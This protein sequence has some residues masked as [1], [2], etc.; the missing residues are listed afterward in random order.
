LGSVDGG[1][2]RG[3]RDLGEGNVECEGGAFARARLYR[4]ESAELN[5]FLLR[6]TKSDPTAADGRDEVARGD[7][8]GKQRVHELVL[9]R[10]RKAGGLRALP[11]LLEVHAAAV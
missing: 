7:A 11:D 6:R 5:A 10:C 1:A 9:G 3:H 8:I 4:D 2:D